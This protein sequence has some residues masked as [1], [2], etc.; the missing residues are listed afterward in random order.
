MALNDDIIDAYRDQLGREP[1]ES[2]LANAASRVSSGT[3]LTDF[4]QDLNRSRE[5]QNYDT[6]Y[7]TSQYRNLFARNPEQ[8]GYQ[9]WLSQMQQ[10]PNRDADV[11]RQYLIDAASA[12]DAATYA[13]SGSW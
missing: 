13:A 8:E 4:E 2:E 3:S 1:T 6:Q 5:G 7:L 9:Y 11:M 10:D 12:M